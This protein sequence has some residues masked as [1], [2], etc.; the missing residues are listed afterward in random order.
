[1]I[2]NEL[3]FFQKFKFEAWLL[4]VEGRET[5]RQILSSVM[6]PKHKFRQPLLKMFQTFYVEEGER[7]R[8]LDTDRER[9]KQRVS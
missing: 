8:E 4:A 7:E 5:G 6:H 2:R 1:M 9:K 3:F